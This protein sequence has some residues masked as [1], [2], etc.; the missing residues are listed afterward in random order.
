[1]SPSTPARANL[2]NR[3]T[4]AR[5]AQRPR[6]VKR[7]NQKKFRRH[8]GRKITL[9][10]K[11]QAKNSGKIQSRRRSASWSVE[12]S[13]SVSA[14]GS[15]GMVRGLPPSVRHQVET[16][17][18]SRAQIERTNVLRERTYTPKTWQNKRS[19]DPIEGT[20]VHTEGERTFTCKILCQL[21]KSNTSMRRRADG[22][23]VHKGARYYPQGEGGAS[24]GARAQNHHKYLPPLDLRHLQKSILGEKFASRK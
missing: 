2:K 12:G 5:I 19:A 3:V 15:E 7:K 18:R 20:N 17:K 8:F 13:A 6:L 23:F 21:A 14:S 22:T 4:C 11:C 1:M 9:L 10:A 24:P 16:N